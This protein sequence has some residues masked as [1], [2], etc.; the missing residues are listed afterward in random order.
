MLVLYLPDFL[1]FTGLTFLI[2][3]YKHFQSLWFFEK[4]L[5]LQPVIKTPNYQNIT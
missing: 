5:L 4:L 3:P 2:N 1:L